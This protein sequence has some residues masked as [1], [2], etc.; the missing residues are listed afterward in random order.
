M[1]CVVLLQYTL[2]VLPGLA[3]L[4]NCRSIGSCAVTLLR[5]FVTYKAETAQLNMLIVNETFRTEVINNSV[6]VLNPGLNRFCFIHS[7][8]DLSS[9]LLLS[10]TKALKRLWFP[11]L[12]LGAILSGSIR[13]LHGR[14]SIY[15]A[16]TCECIDP[17]TLTDSVN[18]SALQKRP[19]H[20]LKLNLMWAICS[21]I[22]VTWVKFPMK[23]KQVAVFALFAFWSILFCCMYY[24][25]STDI[26]YFLSFTFPVHVLFLY[27]SCSKCFSH[28]IIFL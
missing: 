14:G 3:L 7:I 12:Y 23:C 13:C 27:F 19:L 2:P 6:D 18:E 10:L 15:S 28:L 16:L 26:C 8:T 25:G 17:K 1:Q 9:I 22:P 21:D 4:P 24:W 5:A 20:N 11:W